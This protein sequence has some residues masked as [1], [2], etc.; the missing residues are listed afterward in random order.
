MSNVNTFK[1][2]SCYSIRLLG[3][4]TKHEQTP[5]YNFV[6]KEGKNCFVFEKTSEFCELLDRWDRR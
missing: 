5:L 1:T 3:F 4:L 2:Y 6:T